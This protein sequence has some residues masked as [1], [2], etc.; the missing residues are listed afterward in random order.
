M[1]MFFVVCAAL[2]G[3]LLVAQFVLSLVGLGHGDLDHDLGQGLGADVHDFTGHDVA[4]HD[5]AAGQPAAGAAHDHPAP[6]QHG[7]T[8]FFKLLTFR[9]LVA[10]LVFFGLAGLAAES[11]DLAAPEPLLIALGSGGAAMYGVFYLMQLLTRLK[12]DGTE[13][14]AGAVGRAA[15]VYLSIP[16]AHA[17]P[18][19]IQITLQQRWV[20][21][22]AV[23][24]GE[25]LATGTPVVVVD[26]VGPGV[27]E[28]MPAE[29]PGAAG[30]RETRARS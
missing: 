11:A 17:G 21:Y 28:V 14:I 3:T 4:G 30:L 2:G 20:E 7:S 19:K 22:E 18:G 12:S 5:S 10:A 9:T 16:G 26:V 1:E 29:R 13:R 6:A 15:T 27:V 8:G 25:P 24:A 23:T